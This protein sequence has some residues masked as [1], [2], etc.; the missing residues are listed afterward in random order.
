MVAVSTNSGYCLALK[1]NGTVVA[2]GT[3]DYGQ[4]AVP[5]GLNGVVAISAGLLHA[6]AL[7]S[8]GTVVAWGITGSTR[9]RSPQD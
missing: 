3:N 4:T 8:D 2:W 9:W 5:A 6:A 7:K 1:A